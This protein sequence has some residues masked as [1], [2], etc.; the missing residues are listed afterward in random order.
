MIKINPT[1]ETDVLVITENGF[2]KKG[3]QGTKNQKIQN[4]IVAKNENRMK[5]MEESDKE[6]IY[7]YTDGS[8][9]RQGKLVGCGY[10]YFIP[11]INLRISKK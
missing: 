2:G 11:S 1:V 5:E 6:K 3:F 7:I 8:L 10:G 4:A 9:I